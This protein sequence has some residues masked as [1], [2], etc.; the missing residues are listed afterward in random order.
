M[1]ATKLMMNQGK[2][3]DY[4]ED[5]SLLFKRENELWEYIATSGTT[6]ITTIKDLDKG[7]KGVTYCGTLPPDSGELLT[8]FSYRVY[9]YRYADGRIRVSNAL[10]GTSVIPT[11]VSTGFEQPYIAL[12]LFF[13]T[14]TTQTI[15]LFVEGQ[16]KRTATGS[17]N[18]TLTQVQMSMAGTDYVKTTPMDLALIYDR[19]L[20]DE[21]LEQNYKAFL[22]RHR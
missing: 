21:E 4:V 15:S 5:D 8:I 13:P 16:E 3:Y 18:G 7:I 17:W 10:D 2:N 12:T 22:Q 6:K 19:V 11:F 14:E 20:T 9:V 1:Y